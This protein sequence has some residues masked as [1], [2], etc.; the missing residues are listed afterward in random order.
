MNLRTSDPPESPDA[1]PSQE[2]QSLAS[3]KQR[4]E[5][6]RLVPVVTEK[7]E[8]RS[9]AKWNCHPSLLIVVS[10]IH[11]LLPYNDV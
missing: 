5:W 11:S 10:G 2:A 1:G 3:Q 9:C 4:S 8:D 6:H 7:T